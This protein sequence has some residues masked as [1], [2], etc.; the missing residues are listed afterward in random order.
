MRPDSE[1]PWSVIRV[2][3]I[4]DREW[5][6]KSRRGEWNRT[7]HR[8]LRQIYRNSRSPTANFKRNCV[9]IELS[10]ENSRSGIFPCLTLPERR[11][12]G[13]VHVI[14]GRSRF[15]KY[16]VGT[17]RSHVS[18]NMALA[19][20]VP[21]SEPAVARP[22]Q[23]QRVGELTGDRKGIHGAF[24]LESV[25]ASG[26]SHLRHDEHRQAGI[27]FSLGIVRNLGQNMP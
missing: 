10:S 6:S 17:E 9:T 8:E 27:G 2:L 5:E 14:G 15:P 26:P 22:V 20:V 3:N 13:T 1:I 23:S 16:T 24:L 19:E 7:D 12:S 18:A 21:S 11:G 25:G 4:P